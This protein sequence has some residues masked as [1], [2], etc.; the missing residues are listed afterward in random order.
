MSRDPSS[1]SPNGPKSV[2]AYYTPRVAA[3]ALSAWALR[4]ADERA[5]DP[6]AGDGAFLIEAA[7]RSRQLGGGA[8]CISGVEMRPE[9]VR[10]AHQ[11]LIAAGED[12]AHLLRGDFLALS[13]R[14]WPPF[15]AVLGNP[16]FVRFQRLDAEQRARARAAAAGAGA[17]LDPL[18]SLW[19][20][21]VLHATSFLRPGGRLALVLPS[22]VGHARYARSVLAHLRD[23]FAE[24][25]FV[26]FESA[27]F[28]HLDQG[29]VL[30]LAE[31]RGEPFRGFHVAR[32]GSTA[33]LD[34]GLA[35]A[36]RQRL[37][38]D[39]LIRGDVRL[40]HT[41]LPGDAAALLATL[42]SSGSV[43]RLDDH[44]HVSIGYVT[45]HNGFFHLSPER[46]RDLGI[47]AR[48]LRPALFRSRALRGLTVDRDDWCTGAE[49]GLSGYLLAPDG[50]DAALASYLAQGAAIGVPGRT[51]VRRRR[52]WYRVT[53]ADPPD[54][55]LT[56]MSS[57]APRLAVNAS[58]AAVCNTLH[59]VRLRADAQAQLA[60]LLAL[61]SLSSLTELS[62]EL[63]GHALGGGLLKLEPSEALR[64]RLPL[65]AAGETL[66]HAL[67]D[68]LASALDEADRALRAGDRQAAR[69]LADRALL[70]PIA[71]VGPA[72]AA[73]LAD[74]AARLRR[75]R[76]GRADAG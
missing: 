8:S 1:E 18:A 36:P 25:T 6:A 32:L 11:R 28:P 53:R 40:H 22:E 17:E 26:L 24:A 55:V 41:W 2:G 67:T 68:R 34:Q 51:K 35:S 63:E 71:A 13:A 46:A 10:D 73:A 7:R 43:T 23:H 19:A 70:E 45:G 9:A 59:A 76:R 20:P 65:P 58:G 64:L 69:H 30:L 54:M 27:L 37:D 57:G 56:A 12:G 14:H 60:P 4:R 61:A 15:D 48:H 29:T 75:L 52:P 16:P 44:A 42:H 3:R 5:L 62:A 31:G 33:A 72:G 74:A 21:F 38:A 50:D 66:R 39:A 47:A 49:H